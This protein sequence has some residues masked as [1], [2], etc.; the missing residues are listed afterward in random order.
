MQAASRVLRC[1]KR[2]AGGRQKAMR[3][4]I[5]EGKLSQ[6]PALELASVCYHHRLALA[7]LH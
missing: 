2:K 4:A 6:F 1:G 5:A 7:Q 3:D